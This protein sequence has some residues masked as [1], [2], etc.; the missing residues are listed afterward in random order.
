MDVWGR[1]VD[2]ENVAFFSDSVE[3][4]IKQKY[5][6]AGKIYFDPYFTPPT[7]INLR[8]VIN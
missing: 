6:G 5:I 3:K 8:W 4:Q 2:M 1:Q 7:R